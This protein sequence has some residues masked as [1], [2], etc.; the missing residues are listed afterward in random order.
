MESKGFM[1]MGTLTDARV[2]RLYWGLI[3]PVT[4]YGEERWT[5]Q[6]QELQALEGV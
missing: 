6:S 5:L 2:I 1:I 3:R 4:I